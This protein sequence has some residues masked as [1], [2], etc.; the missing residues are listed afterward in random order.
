[1]FGWV[2]KI[3]WI[4]ESAQLWVEL[5]LW[6]LSFILVVGLGFALVAVGISMISSAWGLVCNFWRWC[7]VAPFK[8][9][10]SWLPVLDAR[11]VRWVEKRKVVRREK[12]MLLEA[13]KANKS[14]DRVSFVFSIDKQ[15]LDCWEKLYL[16]HRKKGDS[17]KSWFA[18]QMDTLAM[19]SAW[20]ADS[21]LDADARETK[22]KDLA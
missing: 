5:A 11:W 20:T 3:S 16:K 8:V 13:E 18:D 19:S 21:A 6:L 12:E 2:E 15:T 9:A 14:D 10:F 1:M 7:F 4:P 22:R 17:F